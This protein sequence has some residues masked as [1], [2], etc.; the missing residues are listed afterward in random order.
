MSDERWLVT[1]A[2]GCIGGWT[3]SGKAPPWSPLTSAKTS[4]ASG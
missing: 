4:T 1:G 2:L 3:A